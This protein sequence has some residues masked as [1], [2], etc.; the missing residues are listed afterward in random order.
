MEA[1]STRKE[2]YHFQKPGGKRK[3]KENRMGMWQRRQNRP[4]MEGHQYLAA[5]RADMKKE[6]KRTEQIPRAEVSEGQYDGANSSVTR[7]EVAQRSSGRKK[8]R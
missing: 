1:A 2:V 5:Q 7:S 3:A 4:R 8:E 6:I